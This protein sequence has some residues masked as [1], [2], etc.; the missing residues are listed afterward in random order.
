[1]S[2]IAKRSSTSLS[3]CPHFPDCVACAFSGLPYGEQLARKRQR[4]ADAFS[5]YDTLARVNVPPPVKSP[6]AFGYRNQAKLVARQTRHG[7]LLG[8]YR[9]G[10]HR[11]ANIIDCPVHE[12]RI[13]SVLRAIRLRV[14]RD[15]VPIY[16]ERSGRGWLR[17]V[18][19]RS[20]AWK[21]AVQIILVVRDRDFRG[22]RALTRRLRR[23]P[24]VS[25]VVMNANPT[26]GNVIFGGSFETVA[27][28]DA[29]FERIGGL[30]LRS[31]AGG[32]L[33]ANIAVAR[34]IYERVLAWA[35]PREQD[36][37]VDLYCGVGAISFYVAGR[38]SRVF[39]IED[40]PVAALD[41]KANTRLN[42]FD[43]VRFLAG[44]AGPTLR[45]L[46]GQIGSIDVLTLNPTR[47]GAD[48]IAREAI[49]AAAPS[50]IVYVSCDPESLAR[51]LDWLVQRGYRVRALQPFDLL[52][53][54]DHVECVAS[55]DRMVAH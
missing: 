32:F 10:T 22:E 46:A 15:G 53:Q 37:A 34:R 50:R 40:S 45:R 44:D 18:V 54:T 3:P 5:Q 28:A 19:L 12:P 11:V 4:L 26:T 52:P 33:Q 48:A 7:V 17:Y 1:M 16:D 25:S 24:G 13:R 23:L 41:A 20:S 21:K 35:D 51:D 36:V 42:G 38:A 6:R 39:G 49:L 29:L 27:G 55:L 9:P 31:R 30:K 8:V 2:A 47:K 14:E 43:N